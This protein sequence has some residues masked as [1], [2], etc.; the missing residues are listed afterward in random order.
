M[1]ETIIGGVV[2]GA[3]GWLF[4]SLLLVQNHVTI[5]EEDNKFILEQLHKTEAELREELDVIGNLR[6][7]VRALEVTK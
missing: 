7:R 4:T 3:L 2:L 6:E 5:L 1:K